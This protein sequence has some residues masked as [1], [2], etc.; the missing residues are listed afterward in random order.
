MTSVTRCQGIWLVEVTGWGGVPSGAPPGAAALARHAAR[1]RVIYLSFD[2]ILS[3]KEVQNYSSYRVEIQCDGVTTTS[4]YLARPS[5]LVR[6]RGGQSLHDVEVAVARR[7]EQRGG[8]TGR[9][10][11]H[12]SALRDQSLHDV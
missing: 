7:D 1:E 11:V 5:S 12:A 8:A 10:L 2:K 3:R 6:H 9:R 4:R